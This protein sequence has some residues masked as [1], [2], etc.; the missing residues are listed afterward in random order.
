MSC[1]VKDRWL[2]SAIIRCWP[3][4]SQFQVTFLVRD[5]RDLPASWRRSLGGDGGGR[6]VSRD[7][8]GSGPGPGPGGVTAVY[9]AECDAEVGVHVQAW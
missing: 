5:N 7:V 8:S 1:E 2:R 6:D 9:T 4:P 3:L